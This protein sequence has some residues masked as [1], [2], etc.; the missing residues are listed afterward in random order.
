VD[1][2]ARSRPMNPNRKILR[3]ILALALAGF[4]TAVYDFLARSLGIPLWCPF[5]GSGCDTVQNSP[6]AVILG[7]PLSFLGIL[8]FGAYMLLAGVS[9]FSRA[10]V[11]KLSTEATYGCIY[12]LLALTLVDIF[13]MAYFIYLE[14]TVI[15]AICSLCMF[16]A[17]IILGIGIAL[18][19][20][21]STR[22]RHGLVATV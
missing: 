2:L 16:I 21:V 19:Y 12:V 9:M 20:A 4:A 7:I 11:G 1:L 6:Y 18:V 17:S 10:S 15:H 3:L 14:L 8:G 13:S 22:H 5:A